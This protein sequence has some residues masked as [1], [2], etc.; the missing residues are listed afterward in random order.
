MF[1]I[2]TEKCKEQ[3]KVR[4]KKARHKQGEEIHI[5]QTKYI[6]IKNKPT[7]KTKI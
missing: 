7:Q 5:K 3:K 6:Q 4:Q 1:F 2:V